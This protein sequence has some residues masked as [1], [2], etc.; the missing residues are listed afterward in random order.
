MKDRKRKHLDKK[1]EQKKKF[2]CD[3]KKRYN[4]E[5]MALASAWGSYSNGFGDDLYHYKCGVCSGYHLS[6]RG[7][8][9]SILCERI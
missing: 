1:L 3:N 4:N 7:G 6:S 5:T 8:G 2:N 9:S